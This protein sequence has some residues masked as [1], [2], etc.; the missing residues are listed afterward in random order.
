VND[1]T[2]H[3]LPTAARPEDGTLPPLT[4]ERL[5]G[6]LRARG[7]GFIED[8]EHPEVL[9]TRFDDYRFQFL[10]AGPRRTLLQTRGRWNRSVDAPRK[11]EMLKLCNEWNMNRL[12]PK[13]YVRREGDQSLGLYGE[14]AADFGSGASDEQVDR[15]LEC[16]VRTVVSF[17]HELEARIG[18]ET[19]AVEG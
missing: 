6:A 11:G 13:V 2:T 5:E 16:G 9:R 7:W 10:L 17:F 1:A 19:G 3:T 14:I 4:V 18:E 15:A 8:D 12:W